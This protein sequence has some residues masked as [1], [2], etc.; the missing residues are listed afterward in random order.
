MKPQS[1]LVLVALMLASIFLLW[2]HTGN[3]TVPSDLGDNPPH[4]TVEEAGPDASFRGLPRVS[5][6]DGGPDP[7][8][9]EAADI[10]VTP[11]LPPEQTVEWQITRQE[12]MLEALQ[13]HLASTESKWRNTTDPAERQ[14]LQSQFEILTN[15]LTRQQAEL[16]RLEE[17]APAAPPTTP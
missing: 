15:E 14:T 7:R 8:A 4:P 2:P 9:P 13:R 16:L 11:E 10:E 3:R 12:A 17:L 5:A 1:Y 6:P